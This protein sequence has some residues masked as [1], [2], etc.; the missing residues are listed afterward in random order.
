M[1]MVIN[2]QR[3]ADGTAVAIGSSGKPIRVFWVHLISSGTASSAVIKNG[4]TSSSTTYAQID[5]IAS[6]GVTLNFAGG[7]RLPSGCVFDA[8]ANISSAV[9]GYTE[10][11]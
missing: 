4:T 10:E 7:M 3:V 1:N 11:F 6:Q 2:T 9:I 8:D 5:G